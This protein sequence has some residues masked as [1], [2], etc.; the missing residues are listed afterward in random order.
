[1]IT[2]PKHIYWTYAPDYPNKIELIDPRQ[3]VARQIGWIKTVVADTEYSTPE[4]D[5][6]NRAVFAERP[7][8][9]KLVKDQ[10]IYFDVKQKGWLT[11][12]YATDDTANEVDAWIKSIKP[13]A[14]WRHLRAHRIK[15]RRHLLWSKSNISY[16]TQTDNERL[17]TMGYFDKLKTKYF[18]D[19]V[20]YIDSLLGEV[21]PQLKNYQPE[22]DNQYDEF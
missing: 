9:C 19:D 10:V 21:R 4:P 11:V 5:N 2:I 6:Y 7:Y 20:A 18:S 15:P 16:H 1:M 14:D 12:M 17:Y 13:W 8:D 3:P 22:V